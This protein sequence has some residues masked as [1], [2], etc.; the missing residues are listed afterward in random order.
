MD[1]K[2]SPYIIVLP[3]GLKIDM[4]RWAVDG[5]YLV[6]QMQQIIYTLRAYAVENPRLCDGQNVFA[7]LGPSVNQVSEI[8]KK[9]ASTDHHIFAYFCLQGTCIY[10][11]HGGRVGIFL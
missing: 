8:K 10:T 2:P 5:K 6:N 3:Y 11:V 1:S 9:V 4:M 7:E